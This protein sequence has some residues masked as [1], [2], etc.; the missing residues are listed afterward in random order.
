MT[1]PH[2][3]QPTLTFMQLAKPRTE[4]TLDAVVL[5]LAPIAGGAR[6]LRGGLERCW[7]HEG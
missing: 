2:K 1:G 7:L 6:R 5:E 4:I 3:T